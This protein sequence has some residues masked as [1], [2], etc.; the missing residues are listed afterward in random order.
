KHSLPSPPGLLTLLMSSVAPPVP[1]APG[2]PLSDSEYQ[3][4]FASLRPSWKARVSCQLR[5][6]HG[7]LSPTILQLDQDENHGRVPEGPVCSEFPGAL[8]FQTFCQFAQYRCFKHQFYIKTLLPK[9]LPLATPGVPGPPQDSRLPVLPPT[10]PAPAAPASSPPR[11]RSSAQ[12]QEAWEQRLQKSVRQ[13]ILFA[14]SLDASLG[15]EGSSPDSSNKSDPGS[16]S[17]ST[18][19]GVQEMVPRGRYLTSLPVFLA[20]RPRSLLLSE[21]EAFPLVVLVSCSNPPK[22][23]VT[24]CWKAAVCS[25]SSFL[26]ASACDKRLDLTFSIPFS[27]SLLALKQ[28]ES[29][30]ILCYATLEGNCLSSVL[31]QA[32]KEMEE[33]VLG[34]GDL[35]CDSLGR[36]HMDPCPNCAFCSLKMEQCQN[37]KNLHR[38]R[39]DTGSFTT[40][41]NPQISAQYQAAGNKTSSPETSEYYGMVVFRG[42]RVEYWCSR[43]ATRGCEDLRVML[44]LKA[45][46]SAFQDRDAPSK[47]CDS[48][49][50]QHPSYCAF[51]SHQCLQQSLYNQKVSY[52]SCQRN[53]TYRVLSEKEGEEEVQR[54]RQRFLTLTKG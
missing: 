13:L 11:L 12:A 7:C 49:G 47:I 50:I 28:D 30:M 9:K 38:V 44:W 19:E 15:T 36:H 4:F 54:W 16:T 40:Y 48:G 29:V 14:L 24:K 34:F 1:P 10:L 35:V 51:K 45:E 37:I 27:V 21:A 8:W 52:R 53:E 33:R 22:S 25:F 31:T 41:I 46:Y 39:C 26:L 20:C 6:E 17:G 5:Q 23:E 18:E 43:M 32:W 3:L 42:L 2:S